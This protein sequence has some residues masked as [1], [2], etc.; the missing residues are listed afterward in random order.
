MK[1]NKILVFFAALALLVA[2]SCKD[3]D[4]LGIP[5]ETTSGGNSGITHNSLT[6]EWDKIKD[7]TQYGYELYDANNELVLRDVTSNTKIVVTSLKPATEYT[8]RVWG[9]AAMNSGYTSSEPWV[10]KATTLS[11]KKLGTPVLSGKLDGVTYT[12]SWKSV[13][14]AD[15]YDY[16]LVNSKGDIVDSGSV[17]SRSVSFSHLEAGDYTVSVKATTTNDE[18]EPSGDPATLTFTV[19]IKE[20]WR[21][22]GTYK[23]AVFGNSWTATLVSYGGGNY[24]ILGWYGVEGYDLDFLIDNSDP[25]DT[26]SLV[27]NYSYDGSS[28]CYVVPTGRSEAATLQIYPWYNYS[29][30]TGNQYGGTVQLY[31]YR[32]SKYVTDTFTW[33]SSEVGSPA[34][35]FVGTWN[36]S[37][38]G[39]TYINDNWEEESFSYSNYTV[40]I[41]K[42][43]NT[44]ISMPA[45]YFSDETVN[46][47]I[48]M[49]SKTLTI[50]PK[51]VWTYYTFAGEESEKSPVIG[52]INDDGSLEF[53]NWCAWYDGYLYVYDTKAKLWK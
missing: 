37:I 24:S 15:G 13:S 4:T 35:D 5:L 10:L 43:D 1:L 3:D 33:E 34:D 12:V 31:I 39:M 25:E 38:S 9:F 7:A 23:S 44:T 20:E 48:N 50:E 42:V 16:T 17:S 30:M 47:K 18:Y 22:T 14:K 26:F 46:V 27:G 45:F 41:K 49:A 53:N 52:K 19:N 11:L 8:L 40:E 28:Y 32:N 21:V 51:T 2:P 6:F 36:A 29:S